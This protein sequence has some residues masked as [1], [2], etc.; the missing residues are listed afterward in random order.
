MLK[1]L[2]YLIAVALIVMVGTT[3]V[4]AKNTCHWTGTSNNDAWEVPQ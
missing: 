4:M 1:K 3:N 2:C